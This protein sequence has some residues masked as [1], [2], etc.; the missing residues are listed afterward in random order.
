ML[1]FG[2]EKKEKKFRT[3]RI[4]KSSLIASISI[5]IER[6][7]ETEVNYSNDSSDYGIEIKG[8]DK[9]RMAVWGREIYSILDLTKK[10]NFND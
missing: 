4:N 9:R 1:K 8:L 3:S 2:E 5:L 10:K 6:E 7:R